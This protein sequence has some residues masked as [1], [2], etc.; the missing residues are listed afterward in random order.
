VRSR[1]ITSSIC[2]FCED[3]RQEQNSV[4][5]LVG[6]LPDNINV[7]TT[8]V[9]LP[10]FAMYIRVV[11]P[12]SKIP[13]TISVQLL[14]PWNAEPAK[15]G[16]VSSEQIVAAVD[17]ARAQDSDAVRFNFKVIGANFTVP[18]PGKVVVITSVDKTNIQAGILSFRLQPPST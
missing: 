5:T 1:I 17:E 11:F 3:I 14:T 6:V 16:E 18:N 12:L 15:L 8:P 10:K 2:L 9:V 7:T 4:D 13:S